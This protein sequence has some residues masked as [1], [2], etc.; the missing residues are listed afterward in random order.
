MGVEIENETKRES[1]RVRLP[2]WRGP[3]GWGLAHGSAAR[4][5]RRRHPCRGPDSDERSGRSVLHPQPR[6][7]SNDRDDAG[8]SHGDDLER[9]LRHH[10]VPRHPEVG[11]RRRVP[12]RWCCICCGGARTVV[13]STLVLKQSQSHDAMPGAQ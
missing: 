8:R 12:G 7:R 9:V 6:H 11:H 4:P 2:V 1:H 10:P 13:P 3:R 5:Y